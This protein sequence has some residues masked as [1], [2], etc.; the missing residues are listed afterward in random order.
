MALIAEALRNATV[1]T[2]QTS[3]T[4]SHLASEDTGFAWIQDCGFGGQKYKGKKKNFDMKD[5]LVTQDLMKKTLRKT[6]P[7]S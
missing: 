5:S 2:C 3:Y 7:A 4:H 1:Q 6:V